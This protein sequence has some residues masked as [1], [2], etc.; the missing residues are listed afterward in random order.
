MLV[1]SSEV[2]QTFHDAGQEGRAWRQQHDQDNSGCCDEQN[3]SG[4]VAGL[5]GTAYIVDLAFVLPTI[6]GHPREY[7]G[8]WDSI[9][10]GHYSGDLT[11]VNAFPWGQH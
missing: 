9:P 5:D 2:N 7:P 11:S 4:E 10:R 3:V 8:L 6:K 1:L